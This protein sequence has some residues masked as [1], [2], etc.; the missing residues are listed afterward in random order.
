MNQTLPLA[1]L[2]RPLYYL[3]ND[4]HTVTALDNKDVLTWARSLDDE[5]RIVDE[6]LLENVRIST[7]FIGID[8]RFTVDPDLPPLLFESMTFSDIPELNEYQE[9]YS[10]W[11]EAQDGH[12]RIVQWIKNGIPIREARKQ[13]T[14][15]LK[16]CEDSFLET[17]TAKLNT[18][19]KCLKS[20]D[21]ILKQTS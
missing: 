3:L 11:Q 13:L 19:T 4:D 10:T 8:H 12:N 9:R 2:K 21:S 20:L 6:T 17:Y 5:K 7:V 16:R 14:L 15:N 1:E 18:L